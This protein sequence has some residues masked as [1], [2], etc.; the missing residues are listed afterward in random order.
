MDVMKGIMEG[1]R[2]S[3]PGPFGGLAVSSVRDVKDR[4]RVAGG[5]ERRRAERK[6]DLP[7]SD[8]IQWLLAD[9]T[10]VTVRPSGTEPKIKFYVC[11]A[12]RLRAGP[13][14][15]PRRAPPPPPRRPR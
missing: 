1:Y 13:P 9:G 7:S 8:V 6:I 10:K 3:Q 4:P 5:E 15:C 11:C 14:D 12:R 2:K